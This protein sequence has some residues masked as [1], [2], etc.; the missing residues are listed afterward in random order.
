MSKYNMSMMTLG[1]AAEFAH[2]GIAANS[3]WPATTIA[4]AAVQNLLGGDMLIRRSRKP[5]IV[6]EA[7]FYILSKSA[8]TFSG[9]LILDEDV[10]KA[11]GITDL[12]GY[13]ITPGEKLQKDLFL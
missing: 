12:S 13:A 1:W 8:S 11:E 7:A 3:L 4:T 5:E 10:L 9:N 6:A 2:V